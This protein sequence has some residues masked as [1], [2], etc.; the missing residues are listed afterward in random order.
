MESLPSVITHPIS[1]CAYVLLLAFGVVVKKKH[2]RFFYLAASLSVVALV[3]GLFLAWQQTNKS[4]SSSMSRTLENK[5][6]ESPS[7]ADKK[8]A[9]VEPTTNQTSSGNQSPNISGTKGDVNV[10]FG[11]PA[12]SSADKKK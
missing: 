2:N 4:P 9:T 1:L 3:G 7:V 6:V 8:N 5:K 12:A 10:T 11:N